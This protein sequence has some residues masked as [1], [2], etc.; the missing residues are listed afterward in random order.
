VLVTPDESKN[1]QDSMYI[2]IYCTSS[3]DLSERFYSVDYIW[4]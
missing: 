2:Y 1:G 3:F 4:D